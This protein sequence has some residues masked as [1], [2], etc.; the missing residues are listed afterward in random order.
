MPRLAWLTDLHLNFVRGDVRGLRE[1]LAGV[2]PD[3]VII[4]G[5][6]SEAPTLARDLA[7]LERI[8]WMPA[9]LVLGNHDFY[10][11]SVA[12]VRADVTA[13]C[14]RSTWLRY[15]PV[16]GVVPLGGGS[17]L[18][19]HD[20]W[21]DGRLGDYA[22]SQV[23][24]NDFLLV[25]DLAGRN[26]QDRL[27]RLHALGDEAA[28]HLRE[29]L[30][31]ALDRYRNVVVATHVPPFAEACWHDGRPSDDQHL[32][33]FACAAVGEALR[34]IAAARPD[35]RILVLCGHTHGR[36]VARLLPNLVVKTGGAVYG[37]PAIAEV[38]DASS[39]EGE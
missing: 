24:L 32:P 34:Q 31:R 1:Q 37:Q 18:V 29:V 27:A 4:T 38:I 30:P 11:G 14:Q 19:G 12:A 6:I 22:G 7:A 28:A 20:G 21:A 35:R 17:A 3:G 33:H 10:G 26:A 8:L 16:E 25:E 5:D 39:F 9:W 13:L 36:G 23:V 2:G 15:L